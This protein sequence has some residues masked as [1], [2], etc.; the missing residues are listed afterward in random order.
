MSHEPNLIQPVEGPLP[1]YQLVFCYLPLCLFTGGLLGGALGG[2]AVHCN[3]TV[4][5]S[6][7]PQPLQYVASL[8]L[9]WL[10]ILLYY[11]IAGT[12]FG[13]TPS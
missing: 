9:T 5:R 8:G 7:L 13:R 3:I 12:V 6:N 2:C 4:F 11:L 10:A 1:W